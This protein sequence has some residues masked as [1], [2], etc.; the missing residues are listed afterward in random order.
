VVHEG[1]SRALVIV[2]E[3]AAL[4]KRTFGFDVLHCARCEGR[5]RL[6]ATVTEPK[7]VTRYLGALGGPTGAPARTAT[8]GPPFWKSRVLRRK[9]PATTSLPETDAGVAF[10]QRCV[11]ARSSSFTAA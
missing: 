6:L 11:P 5:L 9:P 1:E 10:R 7:S 8:R 4:L 2:V 3:W